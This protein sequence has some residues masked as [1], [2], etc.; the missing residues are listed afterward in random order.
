MTG[1]DDFESALTAIQWDVLKALRTPTA[2]LRGARR[3][4]A[5][6]LIALGLA[7]ITDGRTKLTPRGREVVLRGSPRLWDVAA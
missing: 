7:T 3:V 4:I 6:Q 1:D 2:D 5:E